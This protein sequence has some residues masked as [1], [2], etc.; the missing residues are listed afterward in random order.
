ME[1]TATKSEIDYYID[2]IELNN[3]FINSSKSFQIQQY[4]SMLLIISYISVVIIFI[5][6][7]LRCSANKIEFYKNLVYMFDLY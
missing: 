7:A 5:I 2:N 3:K 6:I 1:F 4:S